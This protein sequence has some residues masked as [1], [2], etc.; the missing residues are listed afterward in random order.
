MDT[1]HPLGREEEEEKP[2]PS[3]SLH[4]AA[5]NQDAAIISNA[6]DL[7]NGYIALMFYNGFNVEVIS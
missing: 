1:P 7:E 2:Q 4:G 6:S 5:W 3:R